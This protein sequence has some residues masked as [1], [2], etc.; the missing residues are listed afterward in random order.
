M[1]VTQLDDS[2]KYTSFCSVSGYLG[3][4][5]SL[6][7]F[8]KRLGK[9]MFSTM[10]TRLRKNRQY[11]GHLLYCRILGGCCEGYYPRVPL[12]DDPEDGDG[13]PP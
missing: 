3:I 1:F 4:T 9:A 6:G 11:G 12:G 5:T 10:G 7:I 2:G 8:R 13:G